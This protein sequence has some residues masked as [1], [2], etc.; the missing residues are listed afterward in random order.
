MPE[1]G[2]WTLLNSNWDSWK[3]FKHKS[4]LKHLGNTDLTTEYM[5]NGGIDTRQ[6][7]VQLVKCCRHHWNVAFD[8]LSVCGI[9]WGR[10]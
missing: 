7:R 2:T 6:T 5:I 10:T 8:M 4:D 3:H 9:H 1:K